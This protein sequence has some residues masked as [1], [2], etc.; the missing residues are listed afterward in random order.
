MKAFDGITEKGRDGC[1][2]CLIFEY[3][4]N[5][6]KNW[7][8]YLMEA[9]LIYLSILNIIKIISGF[10]YLHESKIKLWRSVPH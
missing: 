4:L 6:S 10:T 7:F 2:S 8:N 9:F 1:F 3:K 5:I